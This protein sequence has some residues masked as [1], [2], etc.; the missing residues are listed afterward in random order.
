MKYTNDNILTLLQDIQRHIFGKVTMFIN[1]YAPT[2]DCK[3]M[4]RLI[5][6]CVFDIND[7]AHCFTFS[8]YNTEEQNKDIFLSVKEV[9]KEFGL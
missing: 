3:E 4:K 7:K 8:D 6:V 2:E 9:I 1:A 5:N